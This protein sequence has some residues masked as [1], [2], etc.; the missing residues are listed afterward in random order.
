MH[1]LRAASAATAARRA[2]DQHEKPRIFAGA[3]TTW[4]FFEKRAHFEPVEDALSVSRAKAAGAWIL[5]KTKCARRAEQTFNPVYG[6][7]PRIPTILGALPGGSSGGSAA[8]L[9]ARFRAAV[10][11]APTSRLAA[12]ASP[13]LRNLRPQADPQPRAW[14]V[15]RRH[16]SC[17]LCRIRTISP[18]SGR[19]LAAAGDL[20]S[21]LDTIAGP[22][23]LV[24]GVGYR[25]ALP[26]PRATKLAGAR[27]L[28]LAQHPLAPLDAPVAAALEALAAGPRGRRR[29]GSRATAT[30]AGSRC[31]GA[32]LAAPLFENGGCVHARRLFRSVRRGSGAFVEA[33]D[34]AGASLWR[35]A[36]AAGRERRRLASDTPPRA[37]ARE[38]A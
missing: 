14:S 6:S 26:P 8:A 3:P 35:N 29:E 22:D 27:V 30:S 15:A 37:A 1:S 9:A 38:L 32:N 24:D 33:V 17:P 36:C 23:D 28:V 21:L 12:R 5:G 13:W 25:L 7:R 19:W 10:G 16:R 20:P 18:S 2:R 34:P 11:S 4:G 31:G